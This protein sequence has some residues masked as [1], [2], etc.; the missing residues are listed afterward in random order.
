[1]F[2]DMFGQFKIDEVDCHKNGW[3]ICNNMSFKGKVTK[4]KVI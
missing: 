2:S 3:Q 4:A 1:M